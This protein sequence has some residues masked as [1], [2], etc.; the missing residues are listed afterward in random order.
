MTTTLEIPDEVLTSVLRL[1][2]AT[3]PQ[4]AILEALRE[5][6]D[7]HDQRELIPLL[8]T[9]DDFMTIEELEQMRSDE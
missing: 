4:D 3:S 6:V 9:L 5:Y 2:G 8:G 1:S 7:R